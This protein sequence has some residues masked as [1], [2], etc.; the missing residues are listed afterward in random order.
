MNGL[1][2]DAIKPRGEKTGEVKVR[3]DRRPHVE[4]H[5]HEIVVTVLEAKGLAKMDLVGE[6]DP[7]VIAG[8]NAATHRT[9]TVD[10]GGEA[11]EFTAAQKNTMHFH[12]A[13]VLESVLVRVF[14]E[15]PGSASTD[16]QIGV[17]E[18]LAPLLAK[19]DKTNAPLG[20]WSHEAWFDIRREM[21]MMDKNV[22]TRTKDDDNLR[23]MIQLAKEKEQRGNSS[24]SKR[25]SMRRSPPPGQLQLQPEPEPSA[26]GGGGG[27]EEV[28]LNPVRFTDDP[29]TEAATGGGASGGPMS[30]GD[31]PAATPGSTE[32]PEKDGVPKQAGGNLVKRKKRE[33]QRRVTQNMMD[34]DFTP[35]T[36]YYRV[37]RR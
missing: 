7:Y 6:N 20:Q 26:G 35:R 14:D 2:N 22:A 30:L 5:K 15:D 3:F 10:G 1:S 25:S 19:M 33:M 9:L 28:V 34:K 16:D 17:T 12:T 29:P 27:G 4:E 31:Q 8:V 13:E 18:E 32:F 21:H 11:C 24:P 23:E 36:D 37:V